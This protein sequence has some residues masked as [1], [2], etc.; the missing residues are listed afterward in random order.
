M[1]PRAVVGSAR[2]FLK[3]GFSPAK[4]WQS[5]E[6]TKPFPF[7]PKQ[8]Q[9]FY[10]P[11]EKS[12]CTKRFSKASPIRAN[13]SKIQPL[14]SN[15]CRPSGNIPYTKKRASLRYTVL[16]CQSLLNSM[17]K[18]AIPKNGFSLPLR[19]CPSE[20]RRGAE[21]GMRTRKYHPSL[22]SLSHLLRTASACAA[23]CRQ[24]I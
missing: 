10:Q 13:L 5:K 3:C 6:S 14:R 2:R 18:Q 20:I 23:S 12:L 11:P 4:H 8:P 24:R 19:V 21:A 9:C 22:Y 15:S 7:K 17:G 16:I 1:G